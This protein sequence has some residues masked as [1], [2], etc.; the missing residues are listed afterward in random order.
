[1][2]GIYYRL[3]CHAGIGIIEQASYT[4]ACTLILGSALSE[5]SRTTSVACQTTKKVYLIRVKLHHLKR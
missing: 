4:F 3:R 2:I 1:M 5:R